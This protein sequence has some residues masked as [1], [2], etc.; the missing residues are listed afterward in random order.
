MATPKPDRR[1]TATRRKAFLAASDRICGFCGKP[2]A[3]TVD[4]IRPLALG[5]ADEEG[6]WRP[7]H[8]SCNSSAG[9]ALGNRM[10]GRA[11]A[12]AKAVSSEMTSDSGLFPPSPPSKRPAKKRKPAGPARIPAKDPGRGPKIPRPRTAGG[13]VL[14]RLETPKAKGVKSLGPE[15]IEWIERSGILGGYSLLPWQRYVITRALELRG[16]RLRWRTVIVTVSRQQG[17]SVALRAL[18]WWRMHQGERFGEPQLLVST[19]NLA[20]TAREVWRPAALHAV[21]MYDDR[22]VSKYG[23]GMEEIDLTEYEHGR[24]LVQAAS[25]NTGVGFSISHVSVD[26]A[27]NVPAETFTQALAPAQSQR[28]QPQA[29]LISTAGDSSSALLRSFREQALQD[30]AGTGD[31]LLIEWSA[32]PEAPYDDPATWR[33]ASPEWS[34][35]RREFLASAVASVPEAVFRTQYLNQWVSTVDG[36]IPASVWAAGE[37]DV[38]PDGIPDAAAVEVSLDGKRFGVVWAWKA[39]DRVIIRGMVTSSA[40][41]VWAELEERRPRSLL[42]PPQLHVHHRGRM[43]SVMVG[44]GEL[45]KYMNGVGRAI[46]DGIVLHRHDDHALTEDVG[47]AVAVTTEAGIRL[48]IRRSPGPIEAARAMVWAVG[49]V[50]RPGAPRPKIRV[51]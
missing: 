22:K 39:G 47:R 3:D 40:S 35:R 44:A 41:R 11:R 2:G 15:A 36:W 4:D 37:S 29:Y 32:P 31:V 1:K 6:N 49:H 30:T 43:R 16:G 50:L 20:S 42:L 14:P 5:G 12:R 23:K 48:S 24:W 26:E 9:A 18:S 7:A 19:A 46:G 33:W 21:R 8:K 45:A 13:M 51:G 28:E 17:K 10:R 38:E 25:E 34:E 27:W